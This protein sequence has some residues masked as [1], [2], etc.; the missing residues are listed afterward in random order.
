MLRVSPHPHWNTDRTYEQA[1]QQHNG[2][3]SLRQASGV[4]FDY[5]GIIGHP[6]ALVKVYARVIFANLKIPSVPLAAIL[7]VIL[8]NKKKLN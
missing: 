2:S 3:G 8:F 5:L 6:E 4:S 1:Y 7:R